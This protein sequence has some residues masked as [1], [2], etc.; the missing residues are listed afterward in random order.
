MT[1]PT[2]PNRWTAL[3]E[4]VRGA[5]RRAGAR[6]SPLT[7]V[8][9]AVAAL[10]VVALVAGAN[11]LSAPVHRDG[12]P[13]ASVTPVPA[14]TTATPTPT[15]SASGTAT[16][17][18]SGSPSP[19]PSTSWPKVGSSAR[20]DTAGLSVDAAGS[21]GTLH[22][23]ALRVETSAKLDADKVG[24]QV[25]DVL[26]DPRS[27]AGS[28]SV[29][30]ALVADAKKADFTITLASPATAK[31]L[32]GLDGGGSCVDGGDAVLDASW[33][34]GTPSTYASRASWQAYLV[35]HGV[36]RLLGEKSQD[37]A[38]KG[39][40]APVMMPQAEDLGGCTS[41]PWPYP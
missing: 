38:K 17:E 39:K 18:P 23:Y 14:P 22:R 20:F 25:A 5:T 37:C 41:N 40:P 32:C 28:G 15:P 16:G 8:S 9:A 13:T 27:W 30:F 31:K 21:S 10:L 26:N 34:K 11:A 4:T 36:G 19:E 2:P 1:Q 3:R 35:N 33:W 29:R 24:R 12:R 7:W 6:I